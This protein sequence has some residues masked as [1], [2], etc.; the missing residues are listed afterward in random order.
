MPRSYQLLSTG[1]QSH[2]HGDKFIMTYRER[3]TPW[4]VVRLLPHVQHLIIRRF[5]A[6]A[7]A[8]EYAKLLRRYA[9]DSEFEVMFDCP[10]TA[11]TLSPPS[12]S[13]PV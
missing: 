4:I 10:M 5:H 13:P 1:L 3:I 8:Q 6:R 2:L 12:D 11:P 9:T 7:N